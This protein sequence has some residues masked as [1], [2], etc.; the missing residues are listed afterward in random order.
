MGKPASKYKRPQWYLN[1]QILEKA[2]NEAQKIIDESKK[3]AIRRIVD[4]NE[5]VQYDV[6][7]YV[8]KGEDKR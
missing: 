5:R 6:H 8:S 7:Q 4:T 1:Q 3:P 2:R